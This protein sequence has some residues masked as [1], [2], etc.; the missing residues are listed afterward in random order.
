VSKDEELVALIRALPSACWLKDREGQYRYLSAEARKLFGPPD[1]RPPQT[2]YDLFSSGFADELAA[3]DRR[4]LETGQ[5]VMTP[6]WVA[7]N[8]SGRRHLALVKFPVPTA[9]GIMVGGLALDLAQ[10]SA[11]AWP[12][13]T[14]QQIL[15]AFSDMI[16]VKGPRSKLRWANR[17]FL[18]AYGMTNAQ[19]QG[20]IDAPF[21]EPDVTQQYVKDDELVFST[22]H[23]LD[24]PEEQMVYHDGT[25]RTCHT[26]KSPIFDEQGHVAMTVA[27]IRDITDKKRLELELRQAQKLE[28][29]GRLA[30][31]M[32][33]EINT[34]IQFVGDQTQFAQTAVG[35]LLGL[36]ARYQALIAKFE[37][38]TVTGADV[39]AIRSAEAEADL[40]Y[41]QQALP[42]A[43]EAALEGVR[44]VSQLVQALKEFGHPDSGIKQAA[45]INAAL[46]STVLVA[47]NEVKYVADTVLDL[48]ELPAVV[49]NI[50]ELKQVF[51]NL[52]VN[53]GHAIGDLH[54]EARGR[55]VITTRVVGNDVVISIADTGCGIPESARTRIFEPFFTTKTVGRGTG[56]GLAISRL[57]VDKHAGSL[58]FETEV[59]RG[60]TFHVRIPRE[61]AVAS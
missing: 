3:H 44:R 55:V 21:V 33:H 4:V 19:L 49:C 54:A 51:L 9:Q 24:I 17:A 61:P 32:A 56:Q 7:D 31:G 53:A 18:Q 48:D 57:V 30:S 36:V 42:I 58:T 45:D 10:F 35:D 60:T 23:T 25:T 5:V 22:G 52:I 13:S 40:G 59:G 50:S 11:A 6:V 20:L 26:V 16:L 12:A 47:A 1:G 46:R 8:L 15:D 38:G 37:A 28:S 34:P 41:V 43:F 39:V 2:A 27:V 29:I 14:Y